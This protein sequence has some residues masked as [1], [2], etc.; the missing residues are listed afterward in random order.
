MSKENKSTDQIGMIEQTVQERLA[1]GK[2]M[3]V[4]ID[5]IGQSDCP[6]LNIQFCT[7]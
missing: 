6:E 2:G 1:Q 3:K 5:G 4:Q 7:G